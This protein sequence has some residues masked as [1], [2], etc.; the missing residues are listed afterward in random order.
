M[1]WSL[2]DE[3]EQ[4]KSL[5]YHWW[6][7]KSTRKLGKYFA[8]FVQ[9]AS[10]VWWKFQFFSFSQN[11]QESISSIQGG[12]VGTVG[13]TEVVVCTY[14][15][16]V[17][18]LT[19]QCIKVSLSDNNM[20]TSLSLDTKAR[21][22]KLK[23][24]LLDELVDK[25]LNSPLVESKSKTFKIKRWEKENDTKI[26]LNWCLMEFQ[27]FQCYQLMI[28][29][30]PFEF[31]PVSD[32]FLTSI[33]LFQMILSK[34]DASYNLSIEIPAPIE[35]V[36]LQSDVPIKLL[37]VD[38]NTAVIS[39][40]KCSA[41]VRCYISYLHHSITVPFENQSSNQFL[42]TYRCQIDTNRVDL[43][44]R[45]IEGQ[46]GKL[47]CYITPS[48]QPKVSQLRKYI[49][50][51]LSMHMRIHGMDETRYCAFG[52]QRW[53][54]IFTSM[55]YR[56]YNTLTLK[57]AF[58]QAEMANW[59]SYCIPE[60]PEKAQTAGNDKVVYYFQNVFSGTMLQCEYWWVSWSKTFAYDSL[61]VNK[62]SMNSY[63]KGHAEFKTENITTLSI[64]RDIIT[65][66]ATKK[67]ITLEIST[68]KFSI[69]N[70]E[71]L[72]QTTHFQISMNWASVLWSNWSNRVW[73]NAINAKKI[74]IYW[75]R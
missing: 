53:D 67:R 32:H 66:N 51:P 47:N 45:T 22:E 26:Q 13:Y 63:S 27:Q 34:E 29:Y 62:W 59:I 35:F 52:I 55:L 23:W 49:I 14:T 69:L 74:I 2:V 6:T 40:S 31:V 42:A 33:A 37:D 60:V 19:T 48:I 9:V 30:V 17:F 44:L 38:K 64:L 54:L 70:F 58:S 20:A 75:W 15:G 24:A 7:V 21:I 28:R 36:L 12:C 25:T 41:M 4:C 18:G 5:V 39:F 71:K 43:K 8:M 46:H 73:S 56:P 57:G 50:R 1:T 68:S 10:F 11:Y 61:D 72:K 65:K 16:R 3:M